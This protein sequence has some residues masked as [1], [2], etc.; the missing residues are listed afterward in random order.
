MPCSQYEQLVDLFLTHERPARLVWPIV[1]RN[2]LRQHAVRLLPMGQPPR[3]AA[4]SDKP[5]AAK[6]ETRLFGIGDRG[7]HHDDVESGR[8]F[9]RR[10]PRA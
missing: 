5:A 7:G 4:L 6:K 3:Q 10:V 2:E 1:F 8:S 9:E